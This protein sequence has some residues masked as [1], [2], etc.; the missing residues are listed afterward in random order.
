MQIDSDLSG[1]SC[2]SVIYTQNKL[3]IANIGNSLCD[4]GKCI[5]PDRDKEIF[6]NIHE[7]SNPKK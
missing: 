3:I 7:E 5:K 6:S 4:L 1:S 2:V